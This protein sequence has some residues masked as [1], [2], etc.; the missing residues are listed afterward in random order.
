MRSLTRFMPAGKRAEPI[1]EQR[2]HLLKAVA[3]AG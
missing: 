3:A 2:R 1:E